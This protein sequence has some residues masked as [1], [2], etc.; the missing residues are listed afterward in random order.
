M[1]G[2][3]AVITGI[4][5]EFNLKWMKREYFTIIV[6]STSFMGALINCTQV[7]QSTCSLKPKLRPVKLNLN[8]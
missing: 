5:D 7:S 3:E 6:I 2:L 4:M 8:A 1:G